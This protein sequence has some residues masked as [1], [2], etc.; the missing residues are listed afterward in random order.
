VVDVVELEFVEKEIDRGHVGD[1][2]LAELGLRGQVLLE[3]SREV[4]N[5][6]PLVSESEALPGDM[7]ADEAGG[8]GDEGATHVYFKS[9][10]LS[11]SNH[12]AKSVKRTPNVSMRATRVAVPA[13]GGGPTK[14][15]TTAQA[16]S[17]MPISDVK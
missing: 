6:D 12:I 10:L 8:S 15:L 9:L 13:F 11:M 4:V 17:A 3:S 1:R 5:S 2:E 16:A 7:R 14:C